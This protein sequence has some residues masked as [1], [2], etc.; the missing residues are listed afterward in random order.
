MIDTNVFHKHDASDKDIISCLSHIEDSDYL[1]CRV[2]PHFPKCVGFAMKRLSM[3]LKECNN[4]NIN[5]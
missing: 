3:K 1:L 4:E 5:I 2:C